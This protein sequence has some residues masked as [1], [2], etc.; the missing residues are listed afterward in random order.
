MFREYTD[1]MDAEM[2]QRATE[3][4]SLAERGTEGVFTSVFDALPE[5]E[6]ESSLAQLIE[7]RQRATEDR[8]IWV[9]VCVCLVLFFSFFSA[10]HAGL[11]SGEA[12]LSLSLFSVILSLS[13]SHPHPH[14]HR[15]VKSSGRTRKSSWTMRRSCRKS[16][17]LSPEPTL[18]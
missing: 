3:Y 7:E 10:L 8:N 15:P 17:S 5:F 11:L 2:Q 14:P 16:V 12:S 4:L 9:K 18:L 6:T 13:L 1:S